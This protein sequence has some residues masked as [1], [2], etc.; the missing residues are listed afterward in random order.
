VYELIERLRNSFETRKLS[1]RPNEIPLR[2]D[3]L[4][5]K[6][7]IMPNELTLEEMLADPIVRLLMRRDGVAED[8]LRALMGRRVDNRVC[9]SSDCPIDH[10]EL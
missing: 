8:D 10:A 7:A 4:K 2:I 3:D 1:S 5:D 9:Q 6:R